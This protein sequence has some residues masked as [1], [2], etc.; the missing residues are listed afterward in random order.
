MSLT[1]HEIWSDAWTADRT[2]EMLPMLIQI[3]RRLHQH[4]ELGTMEHET[5][6]MIRE[7]L[8]QWGISYQYPCADTGIVALVEGKGTD[9]A[10]KNHGA[11]TIGI[12]ADI[13]AL[14]MTED[15]NCPYC[16]KNPG[17]MHACGHDAHM[18]IA[19]GVA[20]LLKKYENQ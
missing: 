5:G 3:R 10:E 6:A 11:K 14:P 1:E 18:T 7:Y 16:S 4:P 15:E 9:G 8:E 17:V 2:E 12:R 13:D 19:L 20:W